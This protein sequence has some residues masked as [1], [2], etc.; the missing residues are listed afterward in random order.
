MNLGYCYIKKGEASKAIQTFSQLSQSAESLLCLGNAHFFNKNYEEAIAFYLRSI[1]FKEDQGT[2]NN[3]GVALKKVGLLQ[4]A[5]YAF[6]D[7]LSI[8]PNTDAATNLLTLYI[9]LGKKTDA[10]QIFKTCGYLIS[11]AET[12]LLMKLFEDKFPNRRTTS[13]PGVQNIFVQSLKRNSILSPGKVQ[14]FGVPLG[15]K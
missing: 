12:K 11:P 3:L 13:A 1:E 7:S 4:D 10:Q 5:I 8:K 2:Y 9:E 14:I 15:K 6:N